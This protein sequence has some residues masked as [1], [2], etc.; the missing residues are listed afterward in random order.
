MQNSLEFS[1][2]YS[3]DAVKVKTFLGNVPRSIEC[4]N[5]MDIYNK[6]SKNDYLQ[7]EPSDAV[8][9]SYLIKQLQASLSKS[10]T[11]S[12]YYVL[13][14]LDK[15]TISEIMSYIESLTESKVHYKIYHTPEVNLNHVLPLFNETIEFEIDL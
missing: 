1:F 14:G 6:L 11:K 9:S 7:I 13:G 3:N 4:I 10:T 15:I 8:V 5:Y 2:V 12:L